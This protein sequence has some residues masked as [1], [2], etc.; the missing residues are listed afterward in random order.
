MCWVTESPLALLAS[1]AALAGV[2]AA[3]LKDLTILQ[4]ALVG[5]ALGTLAGKLLVWRLERR[6]GAELAPRRVR[7]IEATWIAV[8]AVLGLIASL[9]LA[10]S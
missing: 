2:T 8:G 10:L 3:A 6:R 4:D 7:Q 5:V 9:V 1:T